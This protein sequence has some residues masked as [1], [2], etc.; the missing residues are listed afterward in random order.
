MSQLLLHHITLRFQRLFKAKQQLCILFLVLDAQFPSCR[1]LVM[2]DNIQTLPDRHGSHWIL[3]FDMLQSQH[4]M[5]AHPR[6]RWLLA[7]CSNRHHW[8]T[9]CTVAVAHQRDAHGNRRLMTNAPQTILR[10]PYHKGRRVMRCTS[11]S[12]ASGLMTPDGEALVCVGPCDNDST[13][14]V[15]L[16]WL[17]SM[18]LSWARKH[19][20]TMGHVHAYILVRCTP[21]G[22]AHAHI[23]R[24]SICN[25]QLV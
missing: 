10:G 23:A 1:L 25:V 9:H 22:L 19:Y 16:C 2:G 6:P 21:H 14:V 5:F 13:D 7:G 17:G 8:R 12:S 11:S 24:S 4:T 3:L 18:G 20:A 15:P